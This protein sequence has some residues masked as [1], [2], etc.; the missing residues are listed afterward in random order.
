MNRSNIRYAI[1]M[2]LGSGLLLLLVLLSAC[3]REYIPK[4]M[5][6]AWVTENKRYLGCY[7]LISPDEIILGATDATM[8]DYD[9]RKVKSR[10]RGDQ[11]DV[12]IT[13]IDDQQMEVTFSL[14][15]QPDKDDGI[16]YFENQP[17]VVWQRS[18]YLFPFY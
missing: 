9:V 13:A 17:D 2:K 1:S 3:Q 5:V 6:A 14:I 15:F 16:L 10:K 18:D 7:L 8:H 12:A 11:L 4:G